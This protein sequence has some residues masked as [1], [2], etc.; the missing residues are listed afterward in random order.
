MGAKRR[1]SSLE[2]GRAGGS[3]D[4]GPARSRSDP[5]RL[6][7]MVTSTQA[8]EAVAGPLATAEALASSE[9]RERLLAASAA[10]SR[11]LLQAPDVMAV[12]PR[13]LQLMGEAADVDR[14][15]LL[16][17]QPDSGDQLVVASDWSAPTPEALR[18]SL[19]KTVSLALLNKHHPGL[20]ADACCGRAV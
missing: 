1:G 11:L 4:R 16:L 3:L 15:L 9:R 19:P 10:A 17:K 12:V 8:T 6:R 14:V 20:S 5:A 13:V 18:A 7:Y 2:R